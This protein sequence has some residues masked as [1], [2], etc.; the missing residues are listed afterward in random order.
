MSF[1]REE[2]AKRFVETVQGRRRQQS[3]RGEEPSDEDNW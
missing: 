1:E 2:Q 3:S